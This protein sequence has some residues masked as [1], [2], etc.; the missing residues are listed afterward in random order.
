MSDIRLFFVDGKF[1]TE[2][3]RRSVGLEK[4]LMLK[5]YKAS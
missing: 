2:I 4:P 1:V 3:E 5:S